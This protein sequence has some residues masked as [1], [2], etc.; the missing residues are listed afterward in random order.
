MKAR[1]SLDA[2]QLLFHLEANAQELAR[3]FERPGMPRSTRERLKA[4][5][6]AS[7]EQRDSLKRIALSLEPDK[8]P[9][10]AFFEHFTAIDVRA[11]DD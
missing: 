11:S 6:R 7:L 10:P 9:M 8:I 3:Q 2:K 5:R 1:W 4:V